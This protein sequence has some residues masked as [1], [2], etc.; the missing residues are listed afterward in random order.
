MLLDM[1]LNIVAAG[2]AE[3]CLVHVG[4][5]NLSLWVFILIHLELQS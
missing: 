4:C 2:I 5:I 1:L 3:E